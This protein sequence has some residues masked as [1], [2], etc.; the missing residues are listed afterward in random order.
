LSRSSFWYDTW[1]ND[2]D[3]Q[4]S[5]VTGRGLPFYAN[6]LQTNLQYQAHLESPAALVC[7]LTSNHD[8][9][10][11]CLLYADSG[12]GVP[13]FTYHNVV[14]QSEPLGPK[15]Q[16]AFYREPDMTH[17]PWLALFGTP[18]GEGKCQEPWGYSGCAF[19]MAVSN[20]TVERL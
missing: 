9:T 17:R 4:A 16:A 14:A 12:V 19:N 8:L 6:C 7:K 10:T 5:F 20:A 13:G 18:F 11:G 1:I 3:L 15:T 2:L